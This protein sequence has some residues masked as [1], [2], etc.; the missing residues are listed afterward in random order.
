[1]SVPTE[2]TTVVLMLYATTPRDLITA[3]AKMDF[4]EMEKLAG[5]TIARYCVLIY[6]S[7]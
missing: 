7:E 2:R 5:V 3:L 6:Q 1:M 4:M